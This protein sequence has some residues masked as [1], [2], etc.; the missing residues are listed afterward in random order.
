MPVVLFANT[1]G[2]SGKTTAAL[3][4][5]GEMVLANAK[6]VLFEGDP[7]R[8]LAKWA[9][10]RDMPV[11]D[12]DR[13]IST[14]DDASAAIEGATAGGARVVVVHDPDEERTFHWLEAATAW[15][16]FV[17]ADPEG[18]PNEWL[19]A[20]AS[21]AD[22]VVIPFAPTALDTHQVFR[23]VDVLV[24]IGKL[25]KSA[26]P[27]RVLLTK[28]APGAVLTRDETEIRRELA[29]EGGLP[30]I[31]ESLRDRPAF[32]ALFKHHKTLHELSAEEVREEGL[33]PARQNAARFA[34]EIV[35]AVR[36][37]RKAQAA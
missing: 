21:Q 35:E 19:N 10:E 4:F 25:S 2:G 17:V 33:Q 14:A 6:V 9:Q 37:Q 13:R 3:L 20:V 32:R 29:E 27:F 5:A 23:T 28:T 30:M 15:A 34:E 24:R 12:G 7:N 26:V 8:P 18:S 31:T 36:T 11:L 22:L 1:K 16:H